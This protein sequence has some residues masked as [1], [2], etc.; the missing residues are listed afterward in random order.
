MRLT[1]DWRAALDNGKQ[2]GTVLMDLS[3]AF[4]SMPFALLLAKLHAYGMGSDSVKLL[5]IYLIEG[6]QRVKIGCL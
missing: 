2:V 6:K 3:K 1:E 5:S 4:Q